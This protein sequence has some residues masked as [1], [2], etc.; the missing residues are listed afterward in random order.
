M[1]AAKSRSRLNRQSPPDLLPEIEHEDVASAAAVPVADER[2]EAAVRA[3]VGLRWV[4]VL[5]PDGAVVVKST[6]LLAAVEARLD[7]FSVEKA[8]RRAAREAQEDARL[9]RGSHREVI[10]D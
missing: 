3:D 9:V 1:R 4:V 2:V 8:R 5:V 7:D 10:G 6:D